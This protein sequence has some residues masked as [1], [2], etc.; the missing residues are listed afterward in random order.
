[1]FSGSS[2]LATAVAAT[3]GTYAGR[4]ST[5]AIPLAGPCRN[6]ESA[7]ECTAAGSSGRCVAAVIA[8]KACQTARS[9]VWEPTVKQGNARQRAAWCEA[10]LHEMS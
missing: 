3:D 2:R 8:G 6:A 9:R 5:A 1:M 10:L 7:A 4:D